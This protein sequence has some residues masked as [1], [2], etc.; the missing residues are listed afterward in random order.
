MS[1]STT[2]ERR[3]VRSTGRSAAIS[4]QAARE[5]R[6]NSP[7]RQARSCYGHLAGVAGVRLL[8]ELL[9]RRWLAEEAG[10]RP[11]YRLTETGAEALRATGVAAASGGGER[12]PRGHGCLDWTERRLHLGGALGAAVLRAMA[13]GGAVQRDERSRVVAVRT[14]VADWLEAGVAR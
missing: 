14:P 5:V 12:E 1:L 13:A 10:D 2:V 9:A 11:S 3:G 4:A 8:D 6:R 7:I